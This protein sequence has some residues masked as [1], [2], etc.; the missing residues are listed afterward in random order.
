MAPR[1]RRDERRVSPLG[2]YVPEPRVPPAYFAQPGRSTTTYPSGNTASYYHPN[3]APFQP[4]QQPLGQHYSPYEYPQ[5]TQD[6]YYDRNA[7]PQQS[8]EPLYNE[9]G[10]PLQPQ[11]S[12]D[13]RYAHPQQSLEPYL[14]EDAYLRQFP[15]PYL[16]SSAVERAPYEQE[17]LNYAYG[18]LASAIPDQASGEYQ[19]NSQDV[20]SYSHRGRHDTTTHSSTQ[21]LSSYELWDRSQQQVREAG[22]AVQDLSS[23]RG[24]NEAWPGSRG[25]SRD[26]RRQAETSTRRSGRDAS[27]GEAE[28][29]PARTSKKPKR[30]HGSSD[31]VNVTHALGQASLTAPAYAQGGL[32]QDSGKY[33]EVRRT[34]KPKQKSSKEHDIPTQRKLLPR[35]SPTEESQLQP[36]MS[37][38]DEANVK[39]AEKADRDR[40]RRQKPEVKERKRTGQK[41]WYQENKEEVKAK[42]IKSRQEED[43]EV[44]SGRI[45][46]YNYLR[47]GRYDKRQQE[48]REDSPS[49]RR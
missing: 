19:Q 26:R 14:D 31:I 18:T 23:L 25:N 47:R 16:T 42:G 30:R 33:K 45:E 27:I 9:Q 34:T 40:V 4:A 20:P 22:F 24:N 11:R 35:I 21:R 2:D 6:P 49:P 8:Q 7:Y 1:A 44:R 43:P 29:E 15:T 36:F 39:K 12:Y 32:E 13:D 17:P 10:Y 46:R 5:Q 48:Q 37:E 38:Q 3:P 28:V 41:K